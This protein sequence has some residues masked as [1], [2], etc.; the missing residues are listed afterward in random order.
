MDA[1]MGLECKKTGPYGYVYDSSITAMIAEEKSGT[2]Y[3]IGC[4]PTPDCARLVPGEYPFRWAGSDAIAI[5][6]LI[7]ES[8]KNGNSH[9]GVY[10]IL[11]R[12][13]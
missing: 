5:P 10:S 1:P 2:R 13:P 7:T 4:L 11:S 8:E 3:L 6:E 9:T 12:N